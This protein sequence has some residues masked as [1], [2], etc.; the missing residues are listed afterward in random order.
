MTTSGQMF[1]DSFVIQINQPTT[2]AQGYT[3]NY[4]DNNDIYLAYGS[5][6]WELTFF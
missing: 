6:R 1:I 4:I 3:T 2:F 5:I